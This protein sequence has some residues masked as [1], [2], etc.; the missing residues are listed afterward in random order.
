MSIMKELFDFSYDQL[1]VLYLLHQF[2]FL[3]IG[4]GLCDCGFAKRRKELKLLSRLLCL[5]R[6]LAHL[7]GV[8]MV[9]VDVGEKLHEEV[10][11]RHGFGCDFG[12]L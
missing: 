4:I 9:A 3:I 5:L 1:P 6:R 10:P 12:R 11:V 2:Q 8:E 7:G